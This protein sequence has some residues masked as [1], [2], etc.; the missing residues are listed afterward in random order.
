M[1]KRLTYF[2][3]GLGSSSELRDVLSRLAW[4]EGLQLLPQHFQA[5]DDR[6]EGMFLRQMKAVA[7]FSWGLDQLAVDEAA[8]HSGTVRV[9]SAAGQFPDGTVFSFDERRLG[10]LEF[11]ILAGEGTS[12]RRYAIAMPRGDFNIDGVEVRRH[13]QIQGDFLADRNNHSEL[14]AVA[15]LVPNL[16]LCEYDIGNTHLQQIP[17]IELRRSAGGFEVERYHPPT[18]RLLKQSDCYHKI[19][20]LVK[21]LRDKAIELDSPALPIAFRRD[22]KAMLV[23]VV[24]TTIVA[25]LPK[26]EAALAAGGAHPYELLL[27]LCETAGM[28]SALVGKVPDLFP[29]YDHANPAD[30]LLSVVAHIDN[31]IGSVSLEDNRWMTTPFV[32]SNNRWSCPVTVNGDQDL[33]LRI[34]FRESDLD[35]SIKSWMEHALI[36]WDVQEAECTRL[37]IRGARRSEVSAPPQSGLSMKHHQRFLAVRVGNVIGKELIISAPDLIAPVAITDICLLTPQVGTAPGTPRP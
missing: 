10:K 9:L 13:R 34:S 30:S 4:Y 19:S 35:T 24:F 31:I 8:L 20:Q 16:S 23:P 11:K 18:V 25:T 21:R 26:L 27:I 14:A 1:D 15:R 28:L 5:M 12:S 2:D 29:S 3:V 33:I 17:F 22:Y 6:V 36:C 32:L 37:R 7:P